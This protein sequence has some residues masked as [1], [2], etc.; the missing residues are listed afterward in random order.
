MLSAVVAALAFQAPGKP[1]TSRRNFGGLVAGG[2]VAASPLAAFAEGMTSSTTLYK[3]RNTYGQRV[4]AL[5]DA[6]TDT[7]LGEANA[8]KLYVSAYERSTGKHTDGRRPSAAATKILSAA[9]AG[10]KAGANAAVKELVASSKLTKL[11]NVPMV[12]GAKYAFRSPNA[13]RSPSAGRFRPAASGPRPSRRSEPPPSS[14]PCAA[15]P[16][17]RPPRRA[18]QVCRRHRHRRAA[19]DRLLSEQGEMGR[20]KPENR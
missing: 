13:R 20:T 9:A 14:P 19:P 17:P 10:D 7:I 1:L 2:L 12:S 8:I 5:A 16:L 15:T 4:L 11:T 3:A 18:P 6:S